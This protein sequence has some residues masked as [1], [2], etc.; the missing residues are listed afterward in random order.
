MGI[1]SS[2]KHTYIIWKLII[3]YISDT[4]NVIIYQCGSLCVGVLVK[5]K[6][7]AEI[8]RDFNHIRRP[9]NLN[10][11][12]SEAI[13]ASPLLPSAFCSV[14]YNHEVVGQH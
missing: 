10:S 6:Y 8:K 7:Y 2:E 9:V 11:H 12:Y 3:L 5:L 1:F 13:D 14:I 4:T